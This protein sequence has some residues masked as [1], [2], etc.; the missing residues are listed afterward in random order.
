M[1]SVR[2]PLLF[3][4]LLVP[5]AAFC[6]STT[7][8]NPAYQFTPKLNFTEF[9][10]EQAYD[11]PTFGPSIAATGSCSV[12]MVASMAGVDLTSVGPDT[13]VGFQYGNLS[14]NDSLSDADN[15]FPGMSTATFT[16]TDTDPNTGNPVTY[17]TV[18]YTWTATTLTIKATGSLDPF[19]QDTS[20]QLVLDPTQY[21]PAN[22]PETDPVTG[23][24]GTDAVNVMFGDPDN[25]STGAYPTGFAGSTTESNQ[26][27]NDPNFGPTV[28]QVQSMSVSGT[29]LP[30]PNLVI[31]SPDPNTVITTGSVNVL[32]TT[33]SSVVDVQIAVGTATPDDVTESGSN[34]WADTL[35]LAPG[36]NQIVAV[37]T[38][39]NGA[40][41]A[42]EVGVTYLISG[43]LEVSSTGHGSVSKQYLGT[44]TQKQGASIT[45]V[46]T[47]DPGYAFGGWTGDIASYDSTLTFT[48][49]PSITIQAN[50]IPN[51]FPQFAGHYN[52]AFADDNGNSLNGGFSLSFTPTGAFTGKLLI[53]GLSY[54]FKGQ[55]ASDG[56]ANVTV[57]TGSGGGAL[58][59]GFGVLD[60][61]FSLD[62]TD[63][64]GGIVDATVTPADDPT[65]PAALV[66]NR[67]DY[68]QKNRVPQGVN[69]AY[70]AVGSALDTSS[71]SISGSQVIVATLNVSKAGLVSLAGF[72][73]NGATT[74]PFT[75]GGALGSDNTLRFYA[76]IK[77][78]G[79]LAGISGAL[80]FENLGTTQVDGTL[81]V[82]SNNLVPNPGGGPATPNPLSLPVGVAGSTYQAPKPGKHILSQLD[83]D[84]GSATL[85]VGSSAQDNI[86]VSTTNRV[87]PP[88]PNP[89]GLALHFNTAN[90]IFA[91]SFID[92]NADNKR[93]PFRGV[94]LQS[95]N[96]G[97]GFLIE[98][99]NDPVNGPSIDSGDVT[100]QPD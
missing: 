56:T 44:T 67:A 57:N 100:L 13:V 41:T 21:T 12:T 18:I 77:M 24:L 73:D 74:V 69:G 60:I 55:F 83:S 8:L 99:F 23:T 34:S 70:T 75:A 54:S 92:A 93:A 66:G 3:L 82:T 85:T 61:S 20:S 53:Q 88:T 29:A 68:S 45:I 43:T 16:I 86:T 95:Q 81:V 47:P 50:F 39:D 7:M 78:R 14:H 11:D 22:A 31:V 98:S 30:G 17:M 49:Q 91:G 10:N 28:L 25:P 38:D 46:A 59:P 63:P 35:L 84:A 15:W 2:K 97:A 79:Y 32:V 62:L 9:Y 40:M 94:V 87:I 4:L 96:I 90:G 52:G 71:L 48:M 42:E 58:N 51:P 89:D 76:P 26:T 80:A 37:A 19:N 33:D 5:A 65:D 72:Y 27:V 36:L 6:Q 64:A 1:A